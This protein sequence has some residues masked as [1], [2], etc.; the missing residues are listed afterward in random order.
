MKKIT[1]LIFVILLITISTFVY[2]LFP[3]YQPA[4]TRTSYTIKKR[5]C[6]DTLNV[7]FIGDSWAAYHNCYDSALSEIITQNISTPCKVKSVGYVGAKSKEIYERLFGNIKPYI[8]EHPDY[9]II[10]AGINDAVAKMGVD[11]YTGNYVQI[12]HFLISNDITPVVIDMPNVDYQ[13]VYNREGVLSK[14]RH[15]LSSTITG[16]EL[17]SFQSYRTQLRKVIVQYGCKDSIVYVESQRWYN[18][19]MQH[20]LYRTDGVHLNI[21]GYKKLDSCLSK[22]IT[23][24]YNKRKNKTTLTRKGNIYSIKN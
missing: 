3:Y 10:S 24:H 23:T 22:E 4:K 15:L 7:L 9:C 17:Y 13:A 20:S 14:L 2:I 19:N 11:Y 21:K 16:A 8:C 5:H 12:I 1:I 6:A 18:D